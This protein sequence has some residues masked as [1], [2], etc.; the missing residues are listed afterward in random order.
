[1]KFLVAK[2]LLVLG[3]ALALSSQAHAQKDK[4]LRTNPKFVGTFREVVAKPSLSTV[5]ILC[6]GKDAALGMV[7]G[8]DGWISSGCC[9]RG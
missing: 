1:M 3:L 6:D 5:R 9:L 8:A 2:P 4:F 7:V